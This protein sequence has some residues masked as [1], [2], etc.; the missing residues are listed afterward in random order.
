VAVTWLWKTTYSFKDCSFAGISEVPPSQE[1][2]HFTAIR[3]ADKI[4]LEEI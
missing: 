2:G 4:F 1:P 3:D